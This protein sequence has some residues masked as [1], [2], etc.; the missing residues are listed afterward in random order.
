MNKTMTTA[1]AATIGLVGSAAYFSPWFWRHY[2]MSR[3]RREVIQKRALALTYD[4]GPSTALTPQ[5]LDLLRTREAR[6]TFFMLG[7]HAQ[8]HGHIVD[9]VIKEGHDVGCHT[10]QHLNAWTA[11]PWD[12]VA[13]IDAGYERLA[14]WIRPDSMF[15]PPYGKMTLPTYWSIRRRK[16]P[17][18]WWTIDSGDTDNTLPSPGL[19]ADRLRREGGGIVLMHDLDRT[20]PRNEFVLEVTA[21][22]LDVARQESFEVMPLSEICQ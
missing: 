13:D 18:W 7:R 1:L 11:L 19:V 9:R 8:Q 21:A 4:D 6:A 3:V 16:A 15:R 12:G 22:L 17:V 10:D 20:Q 14:R 2:R 5:L